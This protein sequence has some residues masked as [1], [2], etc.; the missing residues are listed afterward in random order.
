MSTGS[1]RLPYVTTKI[2]TPAV[3][4]TTTL[5]SESKI[6][7]QILHQAPLATFHVHGKTWLR[8]EAPVNDV[9]VH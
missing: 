5:P 2:F 3:L 4:I 8:M 9:T 7:L 1:A 6:L